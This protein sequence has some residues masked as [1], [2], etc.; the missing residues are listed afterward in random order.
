MTQVNKTRQESAIRKK[1][2]KLENREIWELRNW[3]KAKAVGQK[4]PIPNSFAP[5]SLSTPPPSVF[6]PQLF[7]KFTT[8]FNPKSSPNSTIIS[9]HC[10]LLPNCNSI[11]HLRRPRWP[12]ESA[13]P[14]NEVVDGLSH[15]LWP[16]II[17]LW[18]AHSTLTYCCFY[19]HWGHLH[20]IGPPYS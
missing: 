15:H 18:V 13:P 6:S 12:L 11:P 9:H 4:S 17:M 5:L 1:R 20:T 8:P 3:P 19:L 10:P 16:A 7:H 2:S 14:C